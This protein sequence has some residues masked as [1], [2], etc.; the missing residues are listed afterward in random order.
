[1]QLIDRVLTAVVLV[2]LLVIFACMFWGG[3]TF[4]QRRRAQDDTAAEKQA[5]ASG[6]A[7]G[8]MLTLTGF[9]LAFTFALAGSHFDSRRQLVIDEANAV[10]GVLM[11]LGSSCVA[12]RGG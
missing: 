4:G 1:M 12:F 11:W 8:A 3:F 2:G 9:L 6:A 5:D 7:L 10:S